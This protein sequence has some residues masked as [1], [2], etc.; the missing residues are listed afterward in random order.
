MM[1]ATPDNWPDGRILQYET[2]EIREVLPPQPAPQKVHRTQW[3]SVMQQ[4][5]TEVP[6]CPGTVLQSTRDDKGATT[7]APKMD[8]VVCAQ[9]LF[10][11]KG[12]KP[13]LQATVFT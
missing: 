7:S 6:S 10:K 2:Q 11:R 9:N 8:Q 13:I 5:L 1:H 4:H 3:L 12:A